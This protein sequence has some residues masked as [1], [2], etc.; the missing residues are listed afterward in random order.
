MG[1]SRDLFTAGDA[2]KVRNVA[3][4]HGARLCGYNPAH[5]PAAAVAA[6]LIPVLDIQ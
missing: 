3:E 2:V 1:L 6:P 4:R 5:Y